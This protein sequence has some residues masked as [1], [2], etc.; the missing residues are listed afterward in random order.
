M[1]ISSPQDV[2]EKKV[3]ILGLGLHGGG[4][5]A[6]Y[7]FFRHGAEVIVNDIKSREELAPS[8]AMLTTLCNE[9]RLAH[10]EKRLISIEYNVG[11]QREEDVLRCDLLIANPGVPRE[12]LLLSLAR[13]RG[14]P[15]HNDASI[16]FSCIRKT[17]TIGVTGT[18]GKTTTATLISEMLKTTYPRTTLMGIATSA[19][20]ISFFTYL[21]RILEDEQ[22]GVRASAVLELSSWQLEI[23]GAWGMGP[24]CAVVTN[25]KPDHLNRY[26][27]MDDYSDAKKNIVRFF[28][29]DSPDATVVLNADDPTLR[30]WASDVPS[31][32][33]YWF[34][35][36]KNAFDRGCTLVTTLV[37]TDGDTQTTLCDKKTLALAGAH[38][39][40][41]ACAAATVAYRYGVTS[42]AICQTL[43]SFRGVPGRL[44]YAGTRE[45]RLF[46]ND[47]TATSPDA[48]CAALA[49]LGGRSKK[50]ILIAGGSDK[51]LLFD[52]L[53]A[54]ITKHVKSLVLLSGTASPHLLSAAAAAGYSGSIDMANSM[55]EAVAK[56]WK[57]AEKCDIILLSPGAA[58]FGLFQHEFDRGNQFLQV[59][60]SL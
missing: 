26:R 3:L 47:T 4:V 14:I 59:I 37:C 46:Y 56:A 32:C 13:E 51:N 6:A 8:I 29:K 49:T 54:A 48:T 53:G 45:G 2:N 55:A 52:V 34:S 17:L 36:K 11:R 24:H 21:D 7:W 44:E 30:A 42:S 18:R 39:G 9:Y 12:S 60:E 57:R 25:I 50:I 31:N 41:N 10:H 5:A 16:F 35:R 19:G 23:L 40:E 38:M 28:Q 20:A 33:L 58:S 43:S 15:I 22:K 1:Q 27:S